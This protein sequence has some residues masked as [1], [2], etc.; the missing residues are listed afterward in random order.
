MGFTRVDAGAALWMERGSDPRL[1]K[2]DRL[3]W[4]R[5]HVLRPFDLR[6]TG[7]VVNRM[8]TSGWKTPIMPLDEATP[9]TTG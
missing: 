6:A 4:P 3:A 8:E 1:S 9:S 2:C 7:K 5:F